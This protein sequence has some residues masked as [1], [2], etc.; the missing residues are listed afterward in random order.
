MWW[1]IG[2]REE[3]D[4]YHNIIKFTVMRKILISI[5]LVAI[6]VTGIFAQNVKIIGSYTLSHFDKSYPIR[7][8][9][10]DSELFYI[11]A[12]IEVKNSDRAYIEIGD[13]KLREFLVSLDEMKHKFQEWSKVAT[14]NNVTDLQKK[15]DIEFPYAR[16]LWRAYDINTGTDKWFDDYIKTLYPD[17]LIL[18][19]GTQLVRITQ[20]V[21]SS[22]NK[23]IYE[24]VHWVFSSTEEID[25]LITQLDEEKIA[26]IVKGEE[27]K[28]ALFK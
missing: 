21:F 25:D 27:A 22:S 16:V 11:Q 4:D 17:F 28:S 14:D 24:T 12:D 1:N 9:I 5:L 7:L 23:Y 8:R 15:M 10:I 13:S 2:Y 6:S 3:K 26:Q 20:V 18:E 19:D